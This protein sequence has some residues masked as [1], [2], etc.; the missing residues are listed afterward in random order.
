MSSPSASIV[1]AANFI[2]ATR[3]TGYRS[4]AAAVAELID[5]A[6]D[7]GATAIQLFI[8]AEPANSEYPMTLAVMDDGCGMTPTTLRTALR[9]G[10]SGSFNSRSGLGRFGMGL[11]NSSLSQCR[12]VEV[13]SWQRI[14][15]PIYTYLDVDEVVTGR[16]RT[17]P[18]PQPCQLP[19]WVGPAFPTGTLVVWSRCD[20]LDRRRV[21]ALAQKLALE[22]GRMFRYALFRGIRLTINGEPIAPRDPLFCHPMAV[23]AGAQEL[24]PSLDYRV[25]SI[26]DDEV[27]NIRVRFSKLPVRLWHNWS[28]EQKRQADISRRAGI[29]VVRAGR[30]IAY[31]WFF[32]RNR[33]KQNYDDWWRCEVTFDPCLDE[34]FGVTHS[35]QGITPTPQLHDLL[36][37]DLVS[38]ANE[39]NSQIR[40]EFS[41]LSPDTPSSAVRAALRNDWRLPR[42]FRTSEMQDAAG[43]GQTAQPPHASDVQ[44]RIKVVPHRGLEFYTWRFDDNTLCLEINQDH[45]FFERVYRPVV[46]G[47]GNVGQR[48]LESL[49]LALARSEAQRPQRDHQLLAEM[50]AAWSNA[51]L[52]FLT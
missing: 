17:I 11:P 47:T 48:Q 52:A 42:V 14:G 38:I 43:I 6:L 32:L 40:R 29:S 23:L 33:R 18:I 22:L 28:V 1:H 36:A 39:L 51:L 35:K 21:G 20:R 24:L 10:G 19:N 9:F 31:G 49:L 41:A 30:E 44:Y 5:N 26:C 4:T 27:G 46:D 2:L 7:A 16:L 15:K 13:Y 8:L 34:W 37:D 25:R 45:P 12:R 3:D 50:R